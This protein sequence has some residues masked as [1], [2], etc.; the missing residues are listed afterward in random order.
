MLHAAGID[1]DCI[2]AAARDLVRRSG[3]LDTTPVGSGRRE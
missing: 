2:A 3:N 1:A